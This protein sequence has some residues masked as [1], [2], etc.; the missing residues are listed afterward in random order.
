MLCLSLKLLEAMAH[1]LH[2]QAASY[3]FLSSMRTLEV[4][5]KELGILLN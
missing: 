3:P 1:V 5:R 4:E 2:A